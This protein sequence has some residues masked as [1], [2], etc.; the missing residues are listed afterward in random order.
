ML[1]MPPTFDLD[2]IAN[3]CT[4]KRGLRREKEQREQAGSR[5]PP[6]E[7]RNY[8]L[9]GSIFPPRF[10]GETMF[11]HISFRGMDDR[12]P[13]KVQSFRGGGGTVR[14]G[15]TWDRAVQCCAP[16]QSAALDHYA[17]TTPQPAPASYVCEQPPRKF[18]CDS[19]PVAPSRSH[20]LNA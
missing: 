2:W 1:L 3:L 12:E 9:L 8:V 7:G 16:K 13:L 11:E 15:T 6:R 5:V 20:L 19:F 17:R 10:E 18:G 14:Y 4:C